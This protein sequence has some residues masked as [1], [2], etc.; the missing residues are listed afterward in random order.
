MKKLIALILALCVC[1]G[2]ASAE[3]FGS[4]LSGLWGSGTETDQTS[5]R[6]QSEFDALFDS[7]K[8]PVL[9]KEYIDVS[10]VPVYVSAEFARA[11]AETLGVAPEQIGD[12]LVYVGSGGM[13]AGEDAKY[14]YPLTVSPDGSKMC[15]VFGSLA[16][17]YDG[18][19]LIAQTISTER[20]V[21]DEDG[22]HALEK[23]L[24][25]GTNTF[26]YLFGS[27]DGVIWSPDGSK[28]VLLNSYAFL[29]T[30][31]PTYSQLMIMDVEAGDVYVAH[32]FSE[33]RFVD[34]TEN[35]DYGAVMGA[36]FDESSRYIYY[37]VYSNPPSLRRHDT[38][39]GE[40]V[41]VQK[42]LETMGE[43]PSRPRLYLMRDGSALAL[44][45]GHTRGDFGLLYMYESAGQRYYRRYATGFE[46]Y[47]RLTSFEMNAQSGLG[48]A[49]NCDVLA[50]NTD[51]SSLLIIDTD[52][53]MDGLGRPVFITPDGSAVRLSKAEY[54][55]QCDEGALPG[56]Y[57]Y[58]YSACLSPDGEYALLAVHT[59]KTRDS[60]MYILRLRTLAL[61]RLELP[62]GTEIRDFAYNINLNRSFLRGIE[63]FTGDVICSARGMYRL[64]WK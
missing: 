6:S 13:L 12:G 53:K 35:E 4:W 39:T 7:G 3:G 49:Y 64:T 25:S 45:E 24:A 37:T 48:I 30:M 36:C 20:S 51:A 19:K 21:P 31:N 14:F 47:G 60:C 8:T 46:P 1:A 57:A 61:L 29:T 44:Y 9:E 62:E 40:D 34:K 56:A 58:I 63:W 23:Q 5:E 32:K 16:L 28:A 18:E 41:L 42:L 2:A 38:E 54:I 26:V 55:K 17:C 11:N 27:T 10:D 50:M 52:K 22:G 33:K 43:Y 15:T 59:P